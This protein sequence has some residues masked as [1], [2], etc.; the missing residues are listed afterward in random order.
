MDPPI[1]YFAYDVKGLAQQRDAIYNTH[2]W[3][4]PS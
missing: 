2:F 3:D 4:N 1:F